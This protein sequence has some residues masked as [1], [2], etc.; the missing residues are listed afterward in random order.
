MTRTFGIEIEGY[1]LTQQIVANAITAAG[2]TCRVEGYGHK[3]SG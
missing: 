3:H 1:G 2:V